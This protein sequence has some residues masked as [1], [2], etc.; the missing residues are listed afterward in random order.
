ML[1]NKSNTL[2]WSV[3]DTKAWRDIG[4]YGASQAKLPKG[5][6]RCDVVSRLVVPTSKPGRVADTTAWF[7]T[8]K[9]IIDGFT[10]YGLWPDDN[11]KVGVRWEQ[12]LDAIKHRSVDTDT[13]VVELTP[14][15]IVD[16]RKTAFDLWVAESGQEPSQRELGAL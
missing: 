1:A 13:I 14:T 7:P 8:M 3:K 4:F 2:H 15:R 6:G 11:S 12:Y 16:A 10:D 5:I 9:A